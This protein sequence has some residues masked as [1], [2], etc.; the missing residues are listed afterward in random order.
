MYRHG[1]DCLE[2]PVSRTTRNWNE[3]AA[4]KGSGSPPNSMDQGPEQDPESQFAG[5]S[6][7]SSGIRWELVKRVRREIAGGVYETPEKW[8]AALEGMLRILD[9]E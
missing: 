3:I 6:G 4:S 9:L 1:P 7:A 5:Q 8:E 2:G